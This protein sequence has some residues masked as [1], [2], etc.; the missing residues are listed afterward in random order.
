MSMR[1]HVVGFAPPDDKWKRMRAVWE[2][3]ETAG[4]SAPPEVIEFFDGIE[5]NEQG[6]EI[7]LKDHDCVSEYKAEMQNGFEIDLRKVPANVQYV[8]FYNSF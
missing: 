3:C 8:R 4:V 1:T 7:D 2:A 6:I 5:P